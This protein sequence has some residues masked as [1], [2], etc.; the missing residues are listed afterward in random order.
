[1]YEWLQ[2]DD[3]AKVALF[4]ATNTTK[5][6]RH[7]LVQRSKVEKNSMLVFIESICDDPEI[8]SQVKRAG[9]CWSFEGI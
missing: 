5:A 6:R 3:G 4:D 2:Q 8:L 9:R 7:L 1:M